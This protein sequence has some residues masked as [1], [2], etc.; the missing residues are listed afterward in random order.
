[1]KK[2]ARAI[3]LALLL[4]LLFPLI[5]L[6]ES[7]YPAAIPGE[8]YVQDFYDVL[9]EEQEQEI[10]VLGQNLEKAT[11]S[12][13]VV[14]TV[15]S[16]EGQ[17]VATYA[18]DVM[19]GYGI[20]DEEKDNGVL[21]IL[22]MDPNKVGNRDVYIGVGYG[23][24]GALPDGKVGRILDEYTYP[25]LEQGDAPG[26]ILSTYQ[27]LYNQVA[28]EYGWDGELATPQEPSP[29]AGSTGGGFSLPM[30]IVGIVVIYLIM[31]MMS[32]GGGGTGSGRRRNS[33]RMFGP[34]GFGGGFGGGGRS[35]G[36]GFGGFGGGSSGGGGAGR[37]W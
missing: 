17:D 8:L 28:T 6:A 23:L 9:S 7:D 12:Q 32:G 2:S 27:L 4:T 11:G 16:L 37:K 5:T 24:E 34:G 13:I 31:Q 29:L 3:S 14:M 33:T 15:E 22:E 21:F 19:R 36:G 26:A 18:V 10:E 30:I 25:F 1:M 20:G 35:S